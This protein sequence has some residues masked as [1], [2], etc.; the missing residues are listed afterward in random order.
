MKT[1]ARFRDPLRQRLLFLTVLW[2]LTLALGAWLSPHF[3]QSSTV[4]YLLQY[5]PVLGL[6]GMGQTLIMLA[7]GPGIDLS[8]G[9]MVSLVGLAIAG[10]YG[11]GLDIYL[12]SLVG[13][14]VGALLGAVNGVL[15]NIVGIPSLMATLATLFVY[16]GLA[17]ALTGGRPLGGIPGEFAWLGQNQTWNLPNQFLFVFLPVTLVLHVLLTRTV[18]GNHIVAAGNDERAAFLVGVNVRRLRLKLYVLS[19]VLA[20]LGAIITVSWFQAARP[21]AGKG[22]ELLSVTAAVLGGTHIFGGLGRISGTL[23]AILI[24][25]TLQ[26]GLQL[27]NISQAWQLGVIGALLIGSVAVDSLLGRRP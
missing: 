20:A 19:G 5:V 18:T 14:L 2:L 10:L 6:L 26:I 23:L 27:A 24:I 1:T 11:L 3:W 15:I 7:G 17:V 12:A 16:S 13:L 4:P 21:D 25:T 9:A 22:L 8:V